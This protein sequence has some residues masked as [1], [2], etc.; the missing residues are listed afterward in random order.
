MIMLTHTHAH[1]HKV[2]MERKLKDNICKKNICRKYFL[3][4][5][6]CSSYYIFMYV[7]IGEVDTFGEY[8]DHL[9]IKQMT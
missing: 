7:H 2:F 3:N 9:K 1:T 6:V 4:P 8:K 5:W